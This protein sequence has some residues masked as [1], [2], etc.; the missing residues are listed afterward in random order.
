MYLE[1]GIQKQENGQRQKQSL[2][3]QNP[4]FTTLF[5]AQTFLPLRLFTS[6]G[7]DA[8][9][10]APTS[11][12]CH[13]SCSEP[14]GS[15]LLPCGQGVHRQTLVDR[16]RLHR[17]YFWRLLLVPVRLSLNLSVW[18]WPVHLFNAATGVDAGCAADETSWHWCDC[19]TA[20]VLLALRC[21]A[22]SW[23]WN[24]DIW[25]WHTAKTLLTEIR[26]SEPG[27]S[28]AAHQAREPMICYTISIPLRETHLLDFRFDFQELIDSKYLW[29][30]V[31]ALLLQ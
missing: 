3:D 21:V 11:I 31:I 28:L 27:F 9:S 18:F 8:K 6:Q 5:L 4:P 13:H 17:Q 15:L 29:C 12:S 25:Q 1:R 19:V 23:H 24:R 26:R 14:R 16:S 22:N 20:N 10:S 30:D 2:K 7:C